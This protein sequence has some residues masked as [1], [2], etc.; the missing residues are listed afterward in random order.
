MNKHQ[1]QI[2]REIKNDCITLKKQKHLT[3]FGYGQLELCEI[4]LEKHGGKKCKQ[5][6]KSLFF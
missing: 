2:I 5:S 1:L 6:S 4:L 3:E